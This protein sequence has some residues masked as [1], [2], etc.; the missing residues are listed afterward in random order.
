MLSHSQTHSHTHSHRGTI[1]KSAEAP[2]NWWLF[3]GK[4]PVTQRHP[5][6]LRLSVVSRCTL[7]CA[8]CSPIHKHIHIHIH[9][10]AWSWRV[11]SSW[12]DVPISMCDVVA[13][14]Y[15]THTHKKKRHP[16][17]YV[18]CSRSHIHHTHKYTYGSDTPVSVCYLV[19]FTYTTHTHTHRGTNLD[20]VSCGSDAPFSVRDVVTRRTRV[21]PS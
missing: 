17:F 9:T 11:L 3:C 6:P 12:L 15:I 19:T 21:S 10:E 14:T 18:W 16:C 7:L 1:L 13:F 5:M 2:Y 20:V 8:W 4:R